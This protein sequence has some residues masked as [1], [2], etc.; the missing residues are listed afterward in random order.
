MTKTIT[1][2]CHVSTKVQLQYS[3]ALPLEMFRLWKMSQNV[4]TFP[5]MMDKTLEIALDRFLKVCLIMLNL[6]HSH[7]VQFVQFS[8]LRSLIGSMLC[9]LAPEVKEKRNNNIILSRDKKLCE[10]TS[11]H[12]AYK[13]F[14]FLVITAINKATS[15]SKLFNRKAKCSSLTRN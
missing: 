15:D 7:Q 11:F 8:Q 10:Q 2:T 4:H 13:H 1:K 9:L 6:D 14:L 3:V 12:K 5:M